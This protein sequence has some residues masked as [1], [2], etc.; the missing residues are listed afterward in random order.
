MV[1]AQRLFDHFPP[2]L[3]ICPRALLRERVA[4]SPSP[5]L[6]GGSGTPSEGEET[7][8]RRQLPGGVCMFRAAAA[9]NGLNVFMSS[10]MELHSTGALSKIQAQIYWSASVSFQGRDLSVGCHGRNKW[11][12]SGGKAFAGGCMHFGNGD[13]SGFHGVEVLD[14][15]TSMAWKNRTIRV[16]WRGKSPNLTS[17]AWNFLRQGKRCFPAVGGHR[18]AGTGA[19]TGEELGMGKHE[20]GREAKKVHDLIH[21]C[22]WTERAEIRRE[23]GRRP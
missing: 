9:N 4:G 20:L 21:G 3:A 11:R 15:S 1:R 5:R 18:E 7:G 16:P 8:W 13:K 14:N 6:P 17:M 12:P 10:R 22:H 2:I 23:W 19:G